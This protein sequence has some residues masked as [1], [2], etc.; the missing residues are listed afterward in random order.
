M[1]N[2]SD[3]DQSCANCYFCISDYPS[4]KSNCHRHSPIPK[5][6]VDSNHW[7]VWP[8][9]RSGDWCGEWVHIEADQPWF[10]DLLI[11]NTNTVPPFS[12]IPVPP[13]PSPEQDPEPV[14]PPFTT[15]DDPLQ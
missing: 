14:A 13:R 8:A 10:S 12:G 1:S 7:A 3:I 15:Y 5:I 9:V 11:R 4:G 2:I 6:N